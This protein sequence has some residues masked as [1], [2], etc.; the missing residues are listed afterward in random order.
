MEE[1]DKTDARKT[2]KV[3][4][5]DATQTVSLEFAGGPQGDFRTYDFIKAVLSM[6]LA[7]CDEA[8]K[9]AMLQQMQAIQQQ[10]SQGEQLLRRLAIR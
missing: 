7:H 8:K 4:W 1:Q 2:L 9:L 10:A 6:A 3:I 5:D